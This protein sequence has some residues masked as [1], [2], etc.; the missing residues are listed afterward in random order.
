M[1]SFRP[2]GLFYDWILQQP[3]G[4]LYPE[5]PESL[6][7]QMNNAKQIINKNF[8]KKEKNKKSFEF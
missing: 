8:T 3:G 6:S 7:K 4:G 1:S 2:R 5:P